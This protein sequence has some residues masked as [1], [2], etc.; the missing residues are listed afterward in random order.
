MAQYY[1]YIVHVLYIKY[2]L[3]LKLTCPATII[4]IGTLRIP[5]SKSSLD[6]SVSND[7]R[8]RNLS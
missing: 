8:G 7:G 2:F 5:P 3:I 6:S 4:L 1:M